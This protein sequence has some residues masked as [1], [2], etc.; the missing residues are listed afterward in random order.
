MLFE[1]IM[2]HVLCSFVNRVQFNVRVDIRVQNIHSIFCVPVM[3]VLR[4]T[5][6]RP[7]ILRTKR[8]FSP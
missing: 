8:K 1:L 3:C 5:F 7:L 6:I 2:R 4:T